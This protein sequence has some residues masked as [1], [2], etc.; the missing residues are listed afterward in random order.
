MTIAEYV[1]AIQQIRTNI[2][3]LL[4]AALPGC[5][6]EKRFIMNGTEDDEKWVGALVNE[7]TGNIR[8]MIMLL[9]E[10]PIGG[11]SGTAGAANFNPRINF[12]F[13][14]FHKYTLG[15]DTTNSED[16]FV[17]DCARFQYA[18]GAGR[19]VGSQGVIERASMRLGIRP[20]KVQS[21]HYGRG[22]A[23]VQLRNIRYEAIT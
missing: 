6:V 19:S 14:L 2:Y 23:V 7:S 3:N 11:L 17:A 4:V 5:E 15:T 13:E 8:I 10:L 22:E 20:S 1:I 9:S 12:Q 16:T 21:L 18:M